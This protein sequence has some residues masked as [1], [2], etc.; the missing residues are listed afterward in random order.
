MRGIGLVAA[1][2]VVLCGCGR[3]SLSPSGAIVRTSGQGA[4]TQGFDESSCESLGPVT[5]GGSDPDSA[6]NDLRN[7][8]ALQGAN[9]VRH[10]SPAA[11]TTSYQGTTTG[12]YIVITGDAYRCAGGGPG[13]GR[14]KPTGIAGFRLGATPEQ[15]RAICTE[16]GLKYEYE[17][18][19]ATCSGTPVKLAVPGR[20]TISFCADKVCQIDVLL[21]APAAEYLDVYRAVRDK[22][23]DKY[24]SPQVSKKDVERCKT[25]PAD[26]VVAGD[27]KFD[28]EWKWPSKHAVALL[29]KAVGGKACV[30]VSY[31]SP[32]KVAESAGSAY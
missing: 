21:D 24:G 9:F 12:A 22:L 5:G 30:L 20:V 19:K 16:P 32:E 25:E 14:E 17:E 31:V 3:H 6:L 29:T 13:E 27:A 8:A 18:N 2:W 1:A 11:G 4:G 7:K 23:R 26:C 28:I 15:T 10:D